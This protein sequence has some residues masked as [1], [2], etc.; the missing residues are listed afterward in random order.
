MADL[1]YDIKVNASD[2]ERNLKNLQT[3]V[4]GLST[5]F[6]KLKVALAGIAFGAA[7]SNAL[8]YADAISDLSDAT[9]IAIQNII[10]FGKAVQ[11]NGGDTETAQKGILKLVQT[12]GDAANGSLEAQNAFADVGVSLRD[13]KMMS[14]QD[15]LA[16]AIKGLGNIT[17][18]SEQATLKAKLFGKEFRKV[19]VEDLG[20]SYETAT[21]KSLAYAASVKS[22]AQVQDRLD[23]SFGNF[24]IALLDVLKPISDLAK[25]ISTNIETTKNWIKTLLSI[26]AVVAGWTLF[27]K[28]ALGLRALFLGLASAGEFVGAALINISIR[29][30]SFG[31]GITAVGAFV[32]GLVADFFAWLGVTSSSLANLATLVAKLTGLGAVFQSLGAIMAGVGATL[33]LWWDDISKSIGNAY[34]KALAFFGINNKTAPVAQGPNGGAGRGGNAETLRLQQQQGEAMRREAEA[35]RE[36]VDALAKRRQEIEKT[37]K[38]FQLSNQD[39]IASIDLDRRMVGQSEQL[40]EIERARAEIQKRTRDEVQKLRDA[41]AALSKDEQGLAGTYDSQ[42][43][44]VQALGKADEKRLI[45]SITGLQSVKM[46]EEFRLKNLENLIKATE[47]AEKRS[48]ALGDAQRAIIGQQKDIEFQRSTIGMGAMEKEIANIQENARKSAL[49]AGR[50]YAQA[51]EDTGDGMTPE[52]AQE[53]AD[54]LAKITEGYKAIAD[55][56]MVNLESSRTW[57]AGW[58]EAMASF[59]DEASN[60]AN[61]VKDLWGSAMGNM[62]SALDKFVET[63]KLNFGDLARSIIMDLMKIALKKAAAGFVGSLF[64]F[65]NGGSP[66][67]GRPSIVGERGP[68]LFVPNVAGKIIPN[69]QLGSLGGGGAVVNNYTYNNNVTAMDAKSVAQLFY[70][71]RHTMFGTVEAAKK[72]MPMRR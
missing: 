51:F 70:D 35:A 3:S 67:V 36:V 37:A 21:Q 31:A 44:K 28:I 5:A 8:Q 15:I 6:D 46:L 68:E 17:S 23:E 19:A 18:A 16:K 30:S 27:G 34:D 2:A 38:A 71:N 10:G 63:G 22:A 66:P 13:L 48:L 60:S 14:E 9:G 65:A 58:K 49:E 7:I 72:E 39:Q 57:S 69:N 42:I 26:A 50:A 24:K 53:F 4:G 33:V 29:L 25:D 62:N 61:I 1:T 45:S 59:V 11:A 20:N 55:A 32:R 52:K 41:K 40:A 64:G 43:S 54:G 47:D 12:I 56:Q